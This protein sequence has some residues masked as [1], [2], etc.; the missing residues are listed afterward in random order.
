MT[1]DARP[2]LTVKDGE[3]PMPPT[4]VWSEIGSTENVAP[5]AAVAS[6]QVAPTVAALEF[7]GEDP[8][9]RRIALRYPFRWDGVVHT[10]IVV[11]RMTVAQM[12][13]FW[14]GLPSDGSYDRTD[15]YGVMCGLPGAVIRALPDPDGP[16]VT[17]AC[18]DFL[19][20]VLGGASD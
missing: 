16:T 14:E 1:A 18:F 13:A 17:A 15:C 3:I 20:R 10:E 2:D 11:H 9:F 19:P 12:G 8:P 5:A 6:T 7:V 4:D